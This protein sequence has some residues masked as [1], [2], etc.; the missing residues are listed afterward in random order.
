M[1]SQSYFTG[2][3]KVNKN[4]RMEEKARNVGMMEGWKGGR[5]E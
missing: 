4:G 2:T 1:I 5:V 3:S